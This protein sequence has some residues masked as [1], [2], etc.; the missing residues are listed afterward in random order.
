MGGTEKK[1]S[2]GDLIYKHS[3]KTT[4][5]AGRDIRII[6]DKPM[7]NIAREHGVEA[8]QVFT[9]ALKNNIIPYRYIRNRDIITLQEQ[10]KLSESCV[11]VIGCGGLGG[12]VILLLARLGIG[13]LVVLDR[14]TFDETNL[15]RQALA[16]GKSIGKFKTRV[17]ADVIPSINPGVEVT[18]Y[19]V[20]LDSNNAEEI[21][22][23]SHVVVDGLDNIAARFVLEKAAKTCGI[24]LVHGALAGFEGQLMT[25]FPEDP[26]LTLIY[27]KDW[28][29]K[30]KS[31][32][33]EALLG[34]PALTAA[35]IANLEA[36]EVL[37]II[38]GRGRL[39][40]NTLVHAD[41]ETGRIDHFVFE[42]P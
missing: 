39:F 12:Q 41:L 2:L 33:A 17:A 32:S 29:D 42:N 38:L 36:V 34:V 23:G 6:K 35:F 26:G 25:I 30:N 8:P 19:N 20:M 40:R 16:N 37:K 9:E 28:K 31:K 3:E 27:G 21:L 5:L 22:R 13:H 14:D 10:L 11:A 4:D 1:G 15:N 24:P 7:L 18:P